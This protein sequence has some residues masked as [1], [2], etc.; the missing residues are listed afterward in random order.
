LTPFSPLPL[1]TIKDYTV[2]E[3]K[4]IQ[5][6]GMA[7]FMSDDGKNNKNKYF[8]QNLIDS[9]NTKISENSGNLESTPKEI[10]EMSNK[11]DSGDN[12]IKEV[13]YASKSDIFDLKCDSEWTYD[14]NSFVDFYG[15][16]NELHPNI[17]Q[18]FEL[19]IAQKN[20]DR[21]NYNTLIADI[22]KYI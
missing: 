7:I 13:F 11:S 5:T 16:R 20:I 4:L 18:I 17:E 3:L 21:I 22:I 12:L 9:E 14:G 1:L 19:Y 8:D 2:E 10:A 6:H 15:T